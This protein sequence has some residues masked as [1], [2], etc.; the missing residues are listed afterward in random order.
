M[1]LEQTWHGGSG[2]QYDF[3]VHDSDAHWPYWSGVYLLC[4]RGA[5]GWNVHHVG[6]CYNLSETLARRRSLPA[7]ALQA[8][9]VHV[10]LESNPITRKRIT[11]DL[12]TAFRRNQ[13]SATAPMLA[14]LSQVA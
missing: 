8:T 13:R 1:F 6:N 9:H 5:D 10:L 12:I 2:R 14:P 4:S 3:Q 7:G 11:R